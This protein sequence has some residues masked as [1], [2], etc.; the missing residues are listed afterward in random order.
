LA[1]TTLFGTAQ[2]ALQ[3]ALAKNLDSSGGAPRVPNYAI[4][5]L[6][7]DRFQS[8]NRGAL[9]EE[10]VRF[11]SDLE[12]AVR[13]FLTANG[14]R[15]GGTGSL[16]LNVVLRAINQDCVV[17]VRTVDRLY[18]L[19]IHD[20]NGQRTVPIKNLHAT[21]GREHDAHTRGF[22]AVHD[23]ARLVSREHL[24]LTYEDLA[25]GCRLLGM[26]PTSINGTPLGHDEVP[27]HNNDVIECG[28]VRITV[29]GLAN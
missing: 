23:G 29:K 17:Q 15:V 26:N 22:V 8:D 19:E 9:A 20:D 4:V 21:I 3:D 25:L 12:S 24:A 11:R 16:I 10:R 14:W 18:E 5:S 27:V 28:H 1:L 7:R 2:L 6:R 13:S